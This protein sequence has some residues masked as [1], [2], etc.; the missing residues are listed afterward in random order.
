MYNGIGLSSVRGTATS[1]HVQYNA[2][3][4]RNSSRRHRTWRNANDGRDGNRGRGFGRGG[5]GGNESKMPLLTSEALKEGANELALHERKRRL[6][7]RLL[8]LRDRL[9]GRGMKDEDIDKEVDGERKRTL[10]GWARQ[11]EER[12]RRIAEREAREQGGEGE[13]GVKLITE[14]G[15]A[16]EG[17]HKA[18]GGDQPPAAEDNQEK[19]GGPQPPQPQQRRWDNPPRREWDRRGR[20]GRHD[21]PPQPRGRGGNNA[22]AQQAFQHERNARLRDAFGINE[23]KHTEGRAF[24]RE[25]Q[26]AKKAEKQKEVEKRE[27]AAR[28]AERAKVREG[29]KKDK[30]RKREERRKGGDKKRDRRGRRARDR[31]KRGKARG[32]KGRDEP[33]IK[34]IRTSRSKSP[35]GKK[36]ARGRSRSGSRSRSASRSR[37]PPAKKEAPKD[38]SPPTAK[39]NGDIHPDSRPTSP[40]APSPPVPPPSSNTNSSDDGGKRKLEGIAAGEGVVVQKKRQSRWDQKKDDAGEATKKDEGEAA[41]KAPG[42]RW[43]KKKSPSHTGEEARDRKLKS[44]KKRDRSASPPS[45]AKGRGGKRRRSRSYSSSSSRSRS[46]SGGRGD[47]KK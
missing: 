13:G 20:G 39:R 31:K 4:V 10:E 40:G 18:E 33:P 35:A 1:G 47:R 16:K 46:P 27:K 43:G 28:K 8:E 45:R 9:E 30:E 29:R 23:E 21:R 17:E 38:A 24:D 14:G 25:Y 19:D 36:K 11:E 12:K 44:A 34:E 32:K 22:Q 26:E 15:E 5:R 3:H 41:K 2:G 37:S 6:E 7:V 42:G